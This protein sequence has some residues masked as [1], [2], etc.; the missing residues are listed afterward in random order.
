MV[1]LKSLYWEPSTPYV[2]NPL[3]RHSAVFIKCQ[4]IAAALR[5]TKYKCSNKNCNLY[6]LRI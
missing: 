2:S 3:C 1:K 6:C 4:D 5:L